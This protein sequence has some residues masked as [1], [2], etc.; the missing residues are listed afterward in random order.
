[1]LMQT[2]TVTALDGRK[3]SFILAVNEY[4]DLAEKQQ[5]VAKYLAEYLEDQLSCPSWA[6]KN[7]KYGKIKEL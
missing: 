3:I 1:M 6:I 2:I 7:V 5:S 4:Q